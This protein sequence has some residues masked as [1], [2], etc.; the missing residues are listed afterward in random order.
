MFAYALAS[1]PCSEATNIEYLGLWGLTMAC[2]GITPIVFYH[3][4]TVC[5]EQYSSNLYTLICSIFC[6]HLV[7][8]ARYAAIIQAKFSYK[9]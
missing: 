1:K 4:A 2:C 6:F 5:L 8:V 7:A 3:I 9:L